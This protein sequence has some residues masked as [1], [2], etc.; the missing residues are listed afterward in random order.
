MAICQA[1]PFFFGL[2][3][4]LKRDLFNKKYRVLLGTFGSELQV[5]ATLLMPNENFSHQ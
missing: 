1:P 3:D 4:A 2:E 5:G